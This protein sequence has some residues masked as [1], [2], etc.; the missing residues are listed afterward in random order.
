MSAMGD[1]ALIA[2]GLLRSETPPEEAR[3]AVRRLLAIAPEESGESTPAVPSGP[4]PEPPD[5]AYDRAFDGV[6]ARVEHEASELDR[7]RS[8]AAGLWAE[9]EE[10]TPESRRLRVRN[11][12]RFHT[13][14]FCERLLDESRD[15]GRGGDPERALAVAG[16]ALEAV[17]HLEADRYGEERL[18]DLQ[19]LAWLAVE[20]ARRL[21]GNLEEARAAL[22]CAT[23]VLGRGTADPLARA[24]LA[25]HEAA[26][27]VDLQEYAEAAEHLDRAIR[28]HRRFGDVDYAGERLVQEA[29]RRHDAEERAT[30][31][32]RRTG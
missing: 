4:P 13:W 31:H 27:A 32:R 3:S 23:E 15:T 1:L 24:L 25:G 30:G 28:L 10:Q 12:Q 19:A 18:A 9:L 21:R 26:L 5:N 8:A 14:A 22:D 6:L 7:E 29:L 17:D 16:L 11:D 2:R 20:E